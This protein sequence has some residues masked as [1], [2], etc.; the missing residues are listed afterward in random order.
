[1]IKYTQFASYLSKACS[2]A[3]DKTVEHEQEIMVDLQT[4][5]IPQN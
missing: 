2:V 1:M 5:L 4:Q 3:V